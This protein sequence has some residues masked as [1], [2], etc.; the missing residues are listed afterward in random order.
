MPINYDNEELTVN[1]EL[2]SDPYS[3]EPVKPKMRKLYKK[4]SNNENYRE[5]PFFD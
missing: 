2:S 1:D 5:N 3:E 4:D